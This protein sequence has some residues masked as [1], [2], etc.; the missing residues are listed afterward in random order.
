MEERKKIEERKWFTPSEKKFIKS[1]SN[2]VCS[3][4]GKPLSDDFTVEHVIPLSK[5]GSNEIENIVALCLDCNTKKDSYIYHPMDYYKYLL[6]NYLDELIKGQAKYYAKFDWLSP[7]SLLPEDIREFKVDVLIKHDGLKSHKRKNQS[8]LV[9]AMTSSIFL[10]KAVYS[11]LD[12][13]YKFYLKYAYKYI[14]PDSLDGVEKTAKV[15]ISDWFDNGAIYYLVDKMNEI[16][17]VLPI[18]FCGYCDDYE[19]VRS[20]ASKQDG[21]VPTFETPIVIKE[22]INYTVATIKA[23]TYILA[24]LS[25]RLKTSVYYIMD[26]CHVNKSAVRA[27]DAIL[28]MSDCAIGIDSF[29]EDGLLR[30]SVF[31]GRWSYNDE[32]LLDNVQSLDN[33]ESYMKQESELKY[34]QKH[35]SF[36]HK[37]GLD[38]WFQLTEFDV[39]RYKEEMRVFAR[40]LA[41]QLGYRSKDSR[42]EIVSSVNDTKAVV[43]ESVYDVIE[44]P[45]DEVK[46]P[47]SVSADISIPSFIKKQVQMNC[48]KCIE[49]DE[50]NNIVAKDIPVLMYLKR[51]NRKTVKCA[52]KKKKVFKLT[53]SELDVLNRELESFSEEDAE[54]IKDLFLMQKKNNNIYTKYSI[55]MNQDCKCIVC[56][57]KFGKENLPYTVLK[58]PRRLGGESTDDNIIGACK[59][60]RNFIGNLSY[61]EKLK[62]L[63]LKE[64][65]LAK[66]LNCPIA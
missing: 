2:G 7:N 26:S 24:N 48:I 43:D 1:K 12:E 31:N 29:N 35:T 62:S 13:I 51:L 59:T 14:E 34:T 55:V 23:Y 45:I 39:P 46:L 21:V 33:I 44:L 18:K 11:D 40:N 17:V 60:C 65:E 38:D 32:A 16:K 15:E 50:D 5:G 52:I 42:I 56:G 63:I 8:V 27:N 58:V 9:P 28:Y 66:E 36:E 30:K 57:S 37:Q 25:K 3:H 49:I 41:R 61:S 64:Y 4:C 22:G 47:E 10:K 19:K 20:S 53:E 54:F 6:P